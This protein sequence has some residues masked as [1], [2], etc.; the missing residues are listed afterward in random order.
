MSDDWNLME[1]KT[2]TIVQIRTIEVR[3]ND[4]DDA[5]DR[6]TDGMG[7]TIDQEFYTLDEYYDKI[8]K[9]V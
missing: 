8:R 2:F 4:R 5:I 1:Y 9:V 6:I 7:R 3:G